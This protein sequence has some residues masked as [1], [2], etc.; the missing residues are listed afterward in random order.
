[1][2]SSEPATRTKRLALF[3][4]D[5]TLLD[6]DSDVLWCDFLVAEGVLE[7]ASFSRRNQDIEARY[8][9]GTIDAAEFAAFYV[10][11]LAGRTAAQWEPLRRKFLA[12]EIVP[13]IPRIAVELV[14]RHRTAGDLV[15]M[16]TATN[17]F[18]TELTAAHFQ[19]EH[20]VATDPEIVDGV[21]TGRAVGVLNMRGGKV[22]RL[23]TWLQD[24]GAVLEQ[25]HSTGYSDSINDLPLLEAVNVAVAVNADPK[26]AA[27][28]A[29]RGWRMISLRL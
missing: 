14:N 2:A 18:L 13:R 5:H 15:V 4:L 25:F 11:T 23:H 26:L 19:I 7:R 24:R 3:D 6:G 16:T 9:G 8:K 27:I 1:M 12:C 20:L 28:A 21:F 10:S 17:R 22:T 29:A